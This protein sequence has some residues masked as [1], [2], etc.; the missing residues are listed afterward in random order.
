MCHTQACT[1][2]VRH[3]ALGC[4]VL[5]VGGKTFS[6]GLSSPIKITDLRR[7]QK[8]SDTHTAF[9]KTSRNSHSPLSPTGIFSTAVRQLKCLEPRFSKPANNWQ[10]KNRCPL[11]LLLQPSPGRILAE[12]LTWHLG[13]TCY[14][15]P[16]PC[17]TLVSW[18]ACACCHKLAWSTSRRAPVLCG[19]SRHLFSE[20]EFSVSGS[21]PS[22]STYKE[23]PGQVGTHRANCSCWS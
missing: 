21:P 7:F 6:A 20:S 19:L 15:M 9:R 16:L 5:Q 11:L 22:A 2:L 18:R 17:H 4:L 1:A 12:L 23:S 10:S 8:Q 13:Q 3:Q 14:L